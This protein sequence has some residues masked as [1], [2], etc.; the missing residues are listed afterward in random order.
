MKRYRILKVNFD[1]QANI[2]KQE[3][4]DDLKEAQKI[5]W[6]DIKRQI[7]EGLVE[8]FGARGAD[9]KISNFVELGWLPISVVAFHNKFLRQVR[10]AYVIGAYYPSLTGACA[11]GE[12]ILNQLIINLRGDFKNTKE[13]KS[14]YRKDSFDNWD[15]AINTLESWS[16]IL[17]D[18]AVDFRKLKEIRNGAIHF[19]PETDRNDKEISLAA[20]KKLTEIV[21]GQ[22][23]GFGT[24]PWF[25]PDIVGSAYIKKEF[26]EQP[27]VKRIILPNCNLVGPF[28]KLQSGPQGWIVLDDYDYEDKEISDEEFASLLKRERP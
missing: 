8:Q 9:N 12:R 20:V 25:I 21:E 24:Q 6:E 28:H 2:L 1:T 15:L 7:R 17:P 4:K 5:H 16:V 13:Y 27:F 3:I 26:E 11:L 18:V 14:V 10:D 22:F 19:D 23:S